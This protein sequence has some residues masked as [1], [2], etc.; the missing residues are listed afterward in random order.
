MCLNICW[1]RPDIGVFVL[2]LVVCWFDFDWDI[3]LSFL[4]YNRKLKNLG[5]SS[6]RFKC[7]H[8]H[9]G[10]R[11]SYIRFVLPR[12]VC[13]HR[14]WPTCIFATHLYRYSKSLSSASIKPICNAT[15]LTIWKRSLP[16]YLFQ[17]KLI[18]FC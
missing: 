12:D 2:V 1:H 8:V 3:L 7:V 6:S 18:P 15:E 17:Y 16:K 9:R 11:Q 13:I 5:S 4:R 14:Y 10:S